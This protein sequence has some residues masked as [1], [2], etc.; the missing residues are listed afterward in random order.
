MDVCL[1][2]LMCIVR[3]RLITRPEDFCHLWCV[4]VWSWSIDNEEALAHWGLLRQLKRKTLYTFWKF[5]LSPPPDDLLTLYRGIYHIFRLLCSSQKFTA[6][7][8]RPYLSLCF[9]FNYFTQ[10]IPNFLP[11]VPTPSPC[12]SDSYHEVKQNE[13]TSFWLWRDINDT[14]FGFWHNV[15]NF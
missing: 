2:W 1:L 14:Q 15:H 13:R 5:S 8:L 10:F 6:L 4:W 7:S 9:S 3:H 11:L 12:L